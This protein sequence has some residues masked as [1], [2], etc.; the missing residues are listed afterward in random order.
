MPS[1]PRYRSK[2]SKKQNM[3]RRVA[4]RSSSSMSSR[5]S[6]SRPNTSLWSSWSNR[7]GWNGRVFDPF[8]VRM[9]VKMRYNDQVTLVTTGGVISQYIFS[10]NGIFDPNITGTGHQPYGFDQY[11]AI[12]NHYQVV[13]STI[14]LS[15]TTP[16]NGS[17]GIVLN[18]DTS[19]SQQYN[20][21]VEEKGA[22]VIQ[23][24][25]NSTNAHVRQYYNAN[26][27]K[28]RKNLDAAMNANPTEQCYFGCF[29]RG[30]TSSTSQSSYVQVSI[31]YIVDLWELVNFGGS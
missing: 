4:T 19:F 22:N 21:V 20:T 9:R 11:A 26:Y 23:V 16:F 29:V 1:A 18:D 28:E 5:A 27:F 13:A 8:P 7:Y 2:R 15:V 25:A 12:Y 31:E 30:E 6:Y 3:E 14:T 17:A 24:G 10:A